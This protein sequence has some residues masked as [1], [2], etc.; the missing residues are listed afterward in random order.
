MEA[1]K[2]HVDLEWKMDRKGEISS[3]V[4]DQKVEVA[5]PPEFPKGMPG[6]WSPEHLF[7]AAVSSCFMTT[8]LAIAEYSNLEFESLTC[9]AEGI[10][11]KKGGKFAMTEIILKPVVTIPNEAEREKAEKIMIKAERACLIS[12]SITSKVHLKTKVFISEKHTA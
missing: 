6:I 12:N 4:L 5:T 9:P 3:P 1:H 2:Y 10:L 11:D 7:T 8:F